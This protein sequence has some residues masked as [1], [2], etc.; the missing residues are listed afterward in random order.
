[1]LAAALDGAPSQLVRPTALR[2]R[3]V[4]PAPVEFLP[5][6]T[7]RP[8][9]RANVDLIVSC[10][11]HG[12]SEAAPSGRNM[13]RSV[14]GA[15]PSHACQTLSLAAAKRGIGDF[16][17]EQ[18]GPATGQRFHALIGPTAAPPPAPTPP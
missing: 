11:R 17:R 2:W 5:P 12:G 15:T 16:L 6:P 3:T 13:E 1:M 14:A 9:A 10:S 4:A 7:R 8:A 18:S